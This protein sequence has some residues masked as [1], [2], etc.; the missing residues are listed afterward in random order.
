[1][2]IKYTTRIKCITIG[3]FNTGRFKSTKTI[4][5][6]TF[7]RLNCSE[8][9]TIRLQKNKIKKNILRPKP[10]EWNGGLHVSPTQS[11]Q[12]IYILCY[13]QTKI[14]SIVVQIKRIFKWI[15]RPSL[16]V[17]GSTDDNQ[18]YV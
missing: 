15:G 8:N 7:S 17:E 5:H 13:D 6:L 18:L 9:Q 14:H 11:Q 2:C 4:L 16:L 12:L 10:V 1:M 3:H